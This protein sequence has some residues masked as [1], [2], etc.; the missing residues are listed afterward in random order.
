[1]T[2]QDLIYMIPE[3]TTDE[4]LASIDTISTL[5]CEDAIR[6]RCVLSSEFSFKAKAAKDGDVALLAENR[7]PVLVSKDKFLSA[8]KKFIYS[9]DEA[10]AEGH[11]RQPIKL[12][13]IFE[14][15]MPPAPKNM[16]LPTWDEKTQSWYDAEY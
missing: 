9:I 16:D 15:D 6:I 5:P 13:Y 7:K 10:I 1:M 2:F 12:P 3:N 14:D 4:A 8:L 11:Y